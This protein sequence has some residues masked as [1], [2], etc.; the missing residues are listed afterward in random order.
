MSPDSERI[1]NPVPVEIKNWTEPVKPPYVKNTTIRTYIIDPAGAVNQRSVQITDFEPRRLRMAIQVIDAAV[2][3]CMEQP[4]TSPD[5]S[6]AT[7]APQGQYLAPNPGNQPYEYFGP[8]AFWLNP[9]ATV[10]RVTV[11]KEYC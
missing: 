11:V 1:A 6:T 2:A 9:L 3:L 8:D 7:Q 5:V 10:T 4:T